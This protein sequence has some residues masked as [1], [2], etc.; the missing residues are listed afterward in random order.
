MR[1][2]IL[3]GIA[4]L[5]GTGRLLGG[6]ASVESAAGAVVAVRGLDAANVGGPGEIELTELARE[7]VPPL[8]FGDIDVLIIER[9][10]KDI[11]GTTMDP[12]VI[13]RFWV[14]G[15]DDLDAP[16]VAAVVL[17]SATEI[18]EGNVQGIGLA[19]F[20][21]ASL[22]NQIDWAA[23]YVNSFTAGP[24]R[25]APVA[26]ADGAARRGGVH[27]GGAVDVREGDR[28]AQ[29]GR[30]H[31]LHVAPDAGVGERRRAGRPAGQRARGRTV[32]TA[33]RPR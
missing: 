28:R 11:S 16:R 1:D 7:L 30:P 21:P 25:A 13:G 22:A 27:Q 19:D 32:E 2:R 4:L 15:L 3:D 10:G 26:T 29:A 8:P 24:G 23:T 33:G 20:V 18:S 6:V 17:L 31:R 14:N 12:N 9:G 5:R